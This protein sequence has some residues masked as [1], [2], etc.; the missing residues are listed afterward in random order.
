[1]GNTLTTA[2]RANII[3]E[4]TGLPLSNARYLAAVDGPAAT[5]AVDGD[6]NLD[7]VG[8]EEGVVELTVTD[9]TTNA[10][11]TL[12]VT[13]TTPPFQITLATPEPK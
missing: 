2:E 11:A 3:D 6:N 7:L 12:D 4:A 1:M 8:V 5:V 10:V 13:V 9:T